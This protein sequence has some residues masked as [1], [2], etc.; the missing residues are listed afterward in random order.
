MSHLKS[1]LFIVFAATHRKAINR[2]KPFL[3]SVRRFGKRA[4][5]GVKICLQC[6]SLRY[7]HSLSCL[8]WAFKE[9]MNECAKWILKMRYRLFIVT[10]IHTF[11]FIQSA[12]VCECVRNVD[13]YVYLIDIVLARV[14]IDKWHLSIKWSVNYCWTKRAR[15]METAWKSILFFVHLL[16]LCGCGQL[17]TSQ[18]EISESLFIVCMWTIIV[19]IVYRESG[20][21]IHFIRAWMSKALYAKRNNFFFRFENAV[22]IDSDGFDI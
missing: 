1:F 11:F 5:I 7:E 2:S 8:M 17:F 4:P 19:S 22:C 3:W 21:H 13:D 16:H 20:F 10:T 14:N 15:E 9:T 18:Q 6:S 12:C